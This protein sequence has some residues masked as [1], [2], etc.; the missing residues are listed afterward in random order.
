MKLPAFLTGKKKIPK[1]SPKPAKGKKTSSKS[2]SKK[3]KG[4]VVVYSTKTCP[5]CKKTKAF[6][7]ENKIPFTTKD[8]GSNQKNAAEMV[9]KSGQKGVPVIDANG[10]IIVGYN[11]S[12]IK[13]ALGM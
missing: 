7:K 10:K 9:K 11:T 4:K 13:K 2:S 5:W 12:A 1:E 6:L 8:V 3:P